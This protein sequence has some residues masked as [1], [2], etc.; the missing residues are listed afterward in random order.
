MNK[1]RNMVADTFC[2]IVGG[3][4]VIGVALGVV[5]PIY[6]ASKVNDIFCILVTAAI[7]AIIGVVCW[8]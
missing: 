3:A 5:L 8:K 4:I 1:L 2:G 6:Y 7:V